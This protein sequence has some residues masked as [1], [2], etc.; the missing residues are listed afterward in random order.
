[1]TAA[2]TTATPPDFETSLLNLQRI[3][4]ELEQGNL[5][6]EASI[7]HY[8]EGIRLFGVCT[9]ILSVAEQRI[10]KLSGFDAQGRPVT[11]PL[12]K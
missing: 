3:V 10:E 1:M 4:R 11:E 9:R 8:E 6:L 2:E 7:Q 5:P 12:E